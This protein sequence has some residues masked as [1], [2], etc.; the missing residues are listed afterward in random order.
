MRSVPVADDRPAGH[1]RER[2]IGGH[3]VLVEDDL[4]ADEALGIGRAWHWAEPTR[5]AERAASF[6]AIPR[7]G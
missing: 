7:A 3:V 4:G 2:A 6:D 1:D 5:T